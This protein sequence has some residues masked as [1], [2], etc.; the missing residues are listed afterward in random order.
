MRTSVALW[1]LSIYGAGNRVYK[2]NKMAVLLTWSSWLQPRERQE[3]LGSFSSKTGYR[4][5]ISR[6]LPS[7]SSLLIRYLHAQRRGPQGNCISYV[8]ESS[9]SAFTSGSHK[10]YCSGMR[11]SLVSSGVCPCVLVHVSMCKVK[12]DIICGCTVFTMWHCWQRTNEEKCV[13]S[14]SVHMT[15]PCG[16]CF[17]FLF[18]SFFFYI[19][20]CT[21][22]SWDAVLC[23]PNC[24]CF[25]FT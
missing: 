15:P 12:G 23:N 21:A 18:F 3:S 24:M 9:T 6:C 2:L 10:G 8:I 20:R 14:C 25:S 5:A 1:C 4:Q 13:L 16:L 17:F 7:P 22:Q 11:K 19:S